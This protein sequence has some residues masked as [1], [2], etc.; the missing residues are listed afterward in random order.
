VSRTYP[1]DIARGIDDRWQ[2]R[3]RAVLRQHPAARNDNHA[4]G[5]YC[6]ACNRPGPIAPTVSEYRGVGLIHHHWLCKSC[7]HEWVTAQSVPT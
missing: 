4:G 6:P 2:R 7:G 1:L 3:T 5:E